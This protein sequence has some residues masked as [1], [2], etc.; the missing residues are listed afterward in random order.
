MESCH[1]HIHSVHSFSL[2]TEL[3][4]HLSSLHSS[5]QLCP[6]LSLLTPNYN[7]ISVTDPNNAPF[8]FHS[9]HLYSLPSIISLVFRPSEALQLLVFTQP[10]TPLT[11]LHSYLQPSFDPFRLSLFTF[12]HSI[13]F[14]YSNLLQSLQ[15]TPVI[16]FHSLPFISFN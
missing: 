7:L 14:I 3:S 11:C 4:F 13:V 15:F 5:I 6:L 8:S 10:F 1:S 16:C 9:S 2:I 12:I